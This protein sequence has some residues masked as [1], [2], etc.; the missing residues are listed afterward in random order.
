MLL[1]LVYLSL[2]SLCLYLSLRCLCLL[3]S[4]LRWL[5]LCHGLIPLLY[6]LILRLLS[7]LLR[8]ALGLI[9][10]WS[11]LL[12][13]SCW[14]LLRGW[15]GSRR[16]LALVTADGRRRAQR[17]LGGL[18]SC[19]G[20]AGLTVITRLR[21]GMLHSNCV[22]YLLLLLLLMLVLSSNYSLRLGVA[23]GLRLLLLLMLKLRLL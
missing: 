22:L 4:L 7:R 18:S 1:R 21:L 23:C 19:W 10:S 17:S 5:R 13:G 9:W 6:L 12:R 14:L 3:L 15:L 16:C 2:C 11:R 20:I 8:C